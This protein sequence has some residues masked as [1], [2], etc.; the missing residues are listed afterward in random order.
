LVNLALLTGNIGKR[1][2]GVNPLRGQNNVQGAAH[3]G[4]DPGIL[5]GSIA[6]EEGRPL[7]ENVWKTNIPE[8]R[9]LNQLQMMDAAAEGKLKALWV[10]GYDVLLSNANAAETERAFEKMDF[11]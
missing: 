1:G 6:V 9:G 3:M 10:I 8:G 11:V 2:S 4:C 5:T 7:F